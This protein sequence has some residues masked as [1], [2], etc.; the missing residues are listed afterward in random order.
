VKKTGAG[1]I[2]ALRFGPGRLTGAKKRPGPA[3]ARPDGLALS[4]MPRIPL[5]TFGLCRDKLPRTG[6]V[7]ATPRAGAGPCGDGL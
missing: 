1:L 4:P 3:P 2:G 7:R 5:I 6:V